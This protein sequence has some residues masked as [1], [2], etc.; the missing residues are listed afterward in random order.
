MD[1]HAAV[2]APPAA[3]RASAPVRHDAPPPS[4]ARPAPTPVQREIAAGLAAG[5]DRPRT[6][7]QEI[8]PTG[9]PHRPWWKRL[10]GV[11]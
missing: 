5:L 2:G 4:F 10:L 9:K 8:L 7:T 6:V 3:P 1:V 11:R